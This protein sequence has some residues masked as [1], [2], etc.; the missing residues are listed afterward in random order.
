M[1]LAGAGFAAGRWLGVRYEPGAAHYLSAGALVCFAVYLIIDPIVVLKPRWI[2]PGAG[3]YAGLSMGSFLR[4][5]WRDE[6]VEP[7]AEGEAGKDEV[8]AELT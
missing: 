8:P 1:G 7:E 6:R 2:S 3:F 4:I 5:L